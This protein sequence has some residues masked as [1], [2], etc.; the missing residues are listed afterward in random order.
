MCSRLILK[1][2]TV[3]AYQD[4]RPISW[5]FQTRLEDHN[6]PS[7]EIREWFKVA[8]DHN[9]YAKYRAKDP[10]SVPRSHELVKHAY[11]DFLAF[12]YGY[13]VKTFESTNLLYGSSWRDAKI[14]FMFTVP[15][16]WTALGVTNTFESLIGEA[17]FGRDGADHTVSVGLTEAEAAAVHT[18]ASQSNAYV[19]SQSITL[20]LIHCPY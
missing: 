7:I 2:P 5:G 17:G 10:K 15:T 3:V 4:G 19:V 8:L 9:E 11:R 12:L 18:F 1:V 14:E 20:T 6:D 16:T 13:I